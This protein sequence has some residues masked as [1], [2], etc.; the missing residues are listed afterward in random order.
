MSPLL[1]DIQSDENSS[2]KVF[3]VSKAESVSLIPTVV[4]PTTEIIELLFLPLT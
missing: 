1:F 3:K 2:F 4:L